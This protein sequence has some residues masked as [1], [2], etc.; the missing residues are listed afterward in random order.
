MD[1]N[2]KT[3]TELNFNG[4]LKCGWCNVGNVLGDEPPFFERA[5]NIITLLNGLDY[6]LYGLTELRSNHDYSINKWLGNL[7]GLRY[8]YVKMY[9]NALQNQFA[10]GLVYDK[11]KLFVLDVKYEWVK[12]DDLKC[13]KRQLLCVKI[14]P[15]ISNKICTVT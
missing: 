12:T 6:D 9:N 5:D 8:D 1:Y 15:V 4:I 13:I 3:H 7:C 11:N 14:A 10:V 2:P